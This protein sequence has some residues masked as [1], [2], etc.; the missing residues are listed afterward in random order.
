MSQASDDKIVKDG[1]HSN[2]VV[3]DELAGILINLKVLFWVTT[4]DFKKG[5]LQIRG[6]LIQ[7]VKKALE[8]E[9]IGLPANIAE[10]KLHSSTPSLPAVTVQPDQPILKP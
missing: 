1:I 2:F 8:N 4:D 5:T 7:K 10:F 6:R 9:G 3:E